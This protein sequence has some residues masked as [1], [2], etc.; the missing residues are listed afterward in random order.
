[1]VKS[2][3]KFDRLF[4]RYSG[5]DHATDARELK[6]ILN[7]GFPQGKIINKYETLPYFESE[8]FI[9]DKILLHCRRRIFK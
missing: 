3:S 5:H 6:K 2:K 7:K 4:N 8:Y 9:I 1:M